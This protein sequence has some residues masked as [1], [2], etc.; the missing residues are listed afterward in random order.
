M[1]AYNITKVDTVLGY[2]QVSYQCDGHEDY[3]VQ[4]YL[5]K[6]ADEAAIHQIAVEAAEEAQQYWDERAVDTPLVLEE[7]SGQIKP[8]VLATEPVYNVASE[9]LD[10][11]WDESGDVRQQVYAIKEYNV[12]LKGS[13]IRS[14]R[15]A[16]LAETDA[17]ALAD[18]SLTEET[19][20]YRQ[21]LRDI[22]DQETFPN[23]VVWPIKP[24]G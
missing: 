9:Y 21:A 20:A 2:I 3:W 10:L 5:P 19:K 8:V 24:I 15:D 6:G 16:L 7:T 1:I 13:N 4:K 17:D 23:S 11:S 18:R 22:T 14:K 12:Q